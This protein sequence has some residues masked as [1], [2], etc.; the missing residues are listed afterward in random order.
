MPFSPNI[1]A[2]NTDLRREIYAGAIFK[3]PPTASSLGMISYIRA[4]L[5][6]R[7]G[8]PLETVQQRLD[9]SDLAERMRI[10]RLE[11]VKDSVCL[12]YLRALMAEFGFSP[13]ENAFD[14][15]RLRGVM[16]NGHLNPA[17]ERAYSLHR[18]TWYAN[19]QSQVN[20]WIALDDVPEERAFSFYPSFFA[21]SVRNNSA[22]F[23]YDAWMNQVGWQS[24]RS[25]R[26]F[27]YPRALRPPDAAAR[28]SFSCRAG[29][30][31]LFSSAH[32][33]QTNPNT[34]GLARFSLD[35]RTV[36]LDDH[37]EG[38]G[39]PNI[40]NISR[41]DAMKDYIFP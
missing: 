36:H 17:L 11:I 7:I 1:P 4:M 16:H 31:L 9:P 34:T 12:D 13:Q 19:P 28:Q 27:D 37:R 32:L 8:V 21:K 41:P 25:Q 26:D 15:L 35:F 40:D 10:L 18:D 23:D 14:P 39:A 30:V 22:D 24:T 33:H 3:S 29:E 38:R 5:S 20:W 6:E 2:D